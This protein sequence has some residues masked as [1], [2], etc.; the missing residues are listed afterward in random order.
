MAHVKKGDLVKVITGDDRGK[1][2][3]IIEICL[4]KNKVKVEGIALSVKHY[5]AKKE[6]EKSE[7]RV[8]ERF[9]H[10]SNVALKAS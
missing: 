4:K 2:G 9:I 10:I 7:R 1:E 6:G 5:K 3:K 8:S